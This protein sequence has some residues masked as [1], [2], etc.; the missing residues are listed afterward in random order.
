MFIQISRETMLF[1]INNLHKNVR[2]NCTFSFNLRV[3]SE[4]STG[5]VFLACYIT[6]YNAN[7]LK[8]PLHFVKF[9]STQ[10]LLVFFK[11]KAFLLEEKISKDKSHIFHAKSTFTLYVARRYVCFVL[12]QSV[13][14]ILL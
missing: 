3:Y 1:L 12:K 6:L 7:S 8:I 2:D 11:A 9:H 4:H 5:K 13:T 10:V 14:V